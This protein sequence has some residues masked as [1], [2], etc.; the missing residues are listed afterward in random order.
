MRELTRSEKN[1]LTVLDTRSGSEI[2]LYYRNPTSREEAL[3]NARLV[4]KKGA[5]IVIR[6]FD[7]REEFGLKILT[8]FRTGDFG[9]DGKP[10]SSDPN[11]PDYR[12]DW[13]RIVA[14]GASD[15]VRTLALTVF[16]GVRVDSTADIELEEAVEEEPAPLERS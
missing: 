3:Y 4:K 5:K 11:D 14:E 2:E 13:K 8:G 9:V 15:I 16:E 6:S 12:D 7:V 1:T 10:I